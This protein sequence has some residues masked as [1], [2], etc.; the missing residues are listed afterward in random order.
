MASQEQ[1][2]MYYEVVAKHFPIMKDVCKT[3]EAKMGLLRLAIYTEGRDYLPELLERATDPKSHP[4]LQ[5]D[6]E[7]LSQITPEQEKEM[8]E[9]EKRALKRMMYMEAPEGLPKE[10][11]ESF[12]IEK[13]IW[14]QSAKDSPE[15]YFKFGRSFEFDRQEVKENNVVKGLQSKGITKDQIQLYARLSQLSGL[16]LT[17]E[18]QTFVKGIR[19]QIEVPK[20][21]LKV[22]TSADRENYEQG[23]YDSV[24]GFTG[25]LETAEG[26][27][28][29]DIIHG[30]LALYYEGSRFKFTNEE[31]TFGM[32]LQIS[33]A[34]DLEI[35]YGFECHSY[36]DKDRGVFYSPENSPA[37][38]YLGT[39]VTATNTREIIPEFKLKQPL[40]LDKT[41]P[42]VIEKGKPI[43]ELPLSDHKSFS[44]DIQVP[45]KDVKIKEQFQQ[46]VEK[47]PLPKRVTSNKGMA[48]DL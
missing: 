7:L 16:H 24:R 15:T 14:I 26:K 29:G 19:E 31:H 38:P 30:S 22:T 46:E 11:M 41:I 40:S 21:I 27:S 42:I 37:N 10:T 35:P 20:E 33:G 36:Y 3:D 48:L 12:L 45:G 13:Q 17:K 34:E 47:S 32:K 5:K 6:L 43:R 25:L 39:G 1:A 23:K 44:K 2:N 8:V 18:E 28:N 4:F 9:R